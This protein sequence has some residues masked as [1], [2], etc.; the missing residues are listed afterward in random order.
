MKIFE[1]IKSIVMLAL[2]GAVWYYGHI[3]FSKPS[4]V[5]EPPHKVE[6]QHAM[7]LASITASNQT[8]NE[9]RR[10]FEAEKSTILKAY[11]DN[12]KKTKETLDELGEVKAQLKQARDLEHRTSDAS[13]TPTDP[14]K[15]EL[16]YEF[17]KIY[18]K[19]YDKVEFP[20]AWA[21]Y[22]PFQE[23]D[24]MWKTGTYQLDY[25]VKVIETENPNGTFNRYAE[26]TVANNQMKETKGKTFKLK[27]TDVGWA[28]FEQNK[29]HFFLWNPRFAVGAVVNTDGVATGFN[30]NT[31]SYGRTTKDMSYRFCTVGIGILKTGD[32]DRSW[33]GVISFEPFSYNLDEKFKYIDNLFIG[34]V[35]S[36]DTGGNTSLGAQISIPF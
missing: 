22:Y 3:Y 25:N 17:K 36:I 23:K 18:A 2:V 20:V 32:R 27:V 15:K 24:K 21:Q 11:E 5:V 13:Y 35:F 4:M 9:L 33:R 10:E 28:K 26:L 12:R 34:P 19:D 31:S 14:D 29:K 8:A 6:I 30:V 1:I 16:S 7:E